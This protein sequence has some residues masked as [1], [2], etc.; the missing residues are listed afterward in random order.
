M[1]FYVIEVAKILVI[2]CRRNYRYSVSG[3]SFKIKIS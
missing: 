1:H 2:D 3:C